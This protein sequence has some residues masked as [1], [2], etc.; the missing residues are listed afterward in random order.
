MPQG[1]DSGSL[2]GYVR[3]WSLLG[4][5]IMGHGQDKTSALVG[6]KIWG[7]AVILAIFI[8]SYCVEE[9]EKPVRKS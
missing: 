5:R 6:G 9:H 1:H 4:P 8:E 3:R 2:G 7:S